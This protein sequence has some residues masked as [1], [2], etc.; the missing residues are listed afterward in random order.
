MDPAPRS[1][2]A[3]NAAVEVLGDPWAILVLRDVMFGNRIRTRREALTGGMP[4]YK[5]LANRFL[6]IF[7]NLILGQNLGEVHS[8][9]RAYSRKVLETIRWQENSDDFVFDQ[10]FI[11]QAS[12]LGFRLGDVPVI[13]IT[14]SHVPADRERSMELGATDF[15]VK[16]FSL[17]SF[18]SL[19]KLVQRVV[20]PAV[21]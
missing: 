17:E 5:Y 16:P 13:V 18:R 9:F 21:A 14:S 8:G 20:P 2:C 11:I 12:A 19:A 10:Q 7:E 1:G 15:F 4:A 3:I 6:T